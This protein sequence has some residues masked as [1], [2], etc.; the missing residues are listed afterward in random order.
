MLGP[1][2]ISQ[3]WDQI[4][5]SMLKKQHIKDLDFTICEYAHKSSAAL[6][7]RGKNHE[8]HVLGEWFWW[9]GNIWIRVGRNTKVHY[10]E[11]VSV[12]QLR[13]VEAE[14]KASLGEEGN[15]KIWQGNSTQQSVGHK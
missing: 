2:K 9:L 6:E 7:W 4:K 10:F 13:G 12:V 11:V 14:V 8:I 15:E 5:K 3:I 1:Q